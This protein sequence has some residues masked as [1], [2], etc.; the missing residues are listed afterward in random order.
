MGFGEYIFCLWV[1]N[2]CGEDVWVD[3]LELFEV[4][5]VN[6]EFVLF[7]CESVMVNFG[8]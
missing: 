8:S 7:G 3:M 4:L 1:R 2:I 6:L 5:M